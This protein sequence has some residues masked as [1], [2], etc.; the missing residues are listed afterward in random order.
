M[1]ENT[2]Y[3][4]I[5]KTKG[6]RNRPESQLLVISIPGPCAGVYMNLK[7]EQELQVFT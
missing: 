5:F 3:T 6:G 7:G 4:H 2:T 1:K